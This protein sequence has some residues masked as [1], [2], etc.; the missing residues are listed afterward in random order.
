[1]KIEMERFLFVGNHPCLDFVNTQ[2]IVKGEPVDVLESVEDLLSWLAQAR[3]LT[4]PQADAVRAG[5]KHTELTSLLNQAKSFRATLRGLVERIVAGQSIPDSA[6]RAINQFL[7]Q[8][9]SY[10]QLVRTKRGFER[11]VHSVA[12][13]ALNILAPLA[14][15]ASDLLCQT[16]FTLI[17]KCGNPACVLYFYD[18]TKNHTRNWCSMQMCGNRMKVAAHYWRNRSRPV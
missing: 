15:S 9:P 4:K 13:P 18:T 1:M 11:R 3:L 12:S 8:R 6:I 14:E 17:K 16:D 2:M 10:A 7:S 5:L